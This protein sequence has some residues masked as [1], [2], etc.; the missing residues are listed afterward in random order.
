MAASDRAERRRPAEELTRSALPGVSELAD[1]ADAGGA[2]GGV[3]GVESVALVVVGLGGRVAGAAPPDRLEVLEPEVEADQLA[4]LLSREDDIREEIQHAFAELQ[5][6]GPKRDAEL[7]RLDAEL[8]NTNATLDRYFQAFENGTMPEQACAPR[9]AKLTRRLSELEARRTEL[10]IDDEQA[11][12][13]LTEEDLRALQAHVAQVI[14]NGDP[15]ARK[16]L[17]QALVQEIRVV[18]RA[19]IYP[20]FYLPVVRPPYG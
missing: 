20:F 3:V 14:Q 19:E 1:L 11:P 9:I 18:S 13:P 16:A 10:A 6:E 8:R 2:A 4:D 17:V 15:P 5:A 12:E 7:E